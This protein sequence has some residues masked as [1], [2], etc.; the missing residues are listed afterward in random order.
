[1]PASQYLIDEAYAQSNNPNN[2]SVKTAFLYKRKV[3][4]DTIQDN[5][6]REIKASLGPSFDTTCLGEE[7]LDKIGEQVVTFL[8]SKGKDYNH[9]EL[10][11]LLK[12]TFSDP[13]IYRALTIES[14]NKQKTII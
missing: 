10:M 3:E 5:L 9:Q 12:N 11:E 2:I 8:V 13:Y 7:M 1:M 14:Q 4:L 6:M